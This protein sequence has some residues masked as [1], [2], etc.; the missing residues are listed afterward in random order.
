MEK[1]IE[2][3]VFSGFHSLVTTGRSQGGLGKG[4]IERVTQKGC[5]EVCTAMQDS[6]VMLLG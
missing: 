5:I 1:E 6:G 3:A 4:S 2:M